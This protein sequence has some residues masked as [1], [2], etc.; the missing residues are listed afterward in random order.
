MFQVDTKRVLALGEPDG[1][2]FLAIMQEEKKWSGNLLRK[3]L[4]ATFQLYCK[5]Q[6]PNQTYVLKAQLNGVKLVG[7]IKETF[8]EIPHIFQYRENIIK[9]AISC[10][11]MICRNDSPEIIMF[12]SKYF[13]LSVANF[14]NG[15]CRRDGKGIQKAQPQNSLELGFVLAVNPYQFYVRFRDCFALPMVTY[16]ELTSPGTSANTLRGGK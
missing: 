7:A 5:N 16:E 11:K 1:F 14:L 4:G 9:A 6:K 3:L 2:T 12:F 8:P 13:P 10:E 15:I